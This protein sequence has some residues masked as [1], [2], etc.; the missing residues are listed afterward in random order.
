NGLNDKLEHWNNFMEEE[1]DTTFQVLKEARTSALEVAKYLLS[2]DPHKK[3]FTLKIISLGE[4]G[5]SLPTEGNFRLNKLLHMCQ[6]FHCVEYG[7]PLFR[8]RMEAFEH[9]ALVYNVYMNFLQLYRLPTLTINLSEETR[10]FVRSI[11]NYFYLYEGDNEALKDFSHEDPA[12]KLGSQQ[13]D[14][15]MPLTPKIIAYYTKFFDDTLAEI[16]GN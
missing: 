10:D 1:D 8:E 16:K 11:F 9:G 7:K 4:E 13:E 12:F 3:Y 2:L 14:G 15:L 6:I 5:S